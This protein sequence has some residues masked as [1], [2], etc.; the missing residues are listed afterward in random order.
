MACA[1]G[2]PCGDPRKPFPL[3]KNDCDKSCIVES[4]RVVYDGPNLPQSGVNTGD[5]LTLCLEKLDNAILQYSNRYNSN[6]EVLTLL[7]A[8][9]QTVQQLS[10]RVTQLEAQ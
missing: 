6:A 5:C 10:Q 7:Q 2:V 9:T 1:P 3:G 8:L 4:V